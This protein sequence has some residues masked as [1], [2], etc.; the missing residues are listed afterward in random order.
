M[1]RGPEETFP[2]RQADDGQETHEKMFSI[3]H[4]ENANQ[5]QNELSSHIC[6]NGYYRKDNT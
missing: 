1:G 6:Q 3:T 5:N 2:Q 4:Q